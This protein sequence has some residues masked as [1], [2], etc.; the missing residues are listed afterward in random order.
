MLCPDCRACQISDISERCG[1]DRSMQV[2]AERGLP[3]A[4]ERYRSEV[5]A[6]HRVWLNVPFAD[7]NT[8]KRMLARWCP[9]VRKWYVDSRRGEFHVNRFTR[10]MPTAAPAP[11]IVEPVPMTV[12]PVAE[13]PSVSFDELL[14]AIRFGDTVSSAVMT[15]APQEPVYVSATER[16]RA[17]TA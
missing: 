17:R 14:E 16:T 11:V 10:W 3:G 12:V 8:V 4:L 5:P 15:A 1:T 7:K 2:R 13:A 9:D 6:A